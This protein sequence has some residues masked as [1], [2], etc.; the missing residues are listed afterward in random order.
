M[1]LGCIVLQLFCHYNVILPLKYVFCFY[2]S[3]LCS[4]CAVYNM[5][6]FCSPLIL[7]FPGMFLRFCL[8][9]FEMVPGAPI[10]TGITFAFLFHMC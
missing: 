6:V 5:A 9:D 4:M 3:T 8:S 1:F 2:I 10:P 7:C